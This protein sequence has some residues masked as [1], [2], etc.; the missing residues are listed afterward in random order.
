M[1]ITKRLDIGDRV[2]VEA[3]LDK[4][5]E[6]GTVREVRG[7]RFGAGYGIGIVGRHGNEIV[8]HYDKEDIITVLET[9][10]DEALWIMINS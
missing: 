8:Y 2:V 9:E 1:G 3:F 7:T 5:G 6:I 4:A 10:E